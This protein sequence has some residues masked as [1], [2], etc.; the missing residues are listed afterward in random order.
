MGSSC[1][2]SAGRVR[3]SGR[4]SILEGTTTTEAICWVSL[5]AGRGVAEAFFCLLLRMK[6]ARTA[7]MMSSATTAIQM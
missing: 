7:P 1:S 6:T 3:L 4:M 2:V 5:A